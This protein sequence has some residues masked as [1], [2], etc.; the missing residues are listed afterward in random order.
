LAALLAP[1]VLWPVPADAGGYRLPDQDPEAIARGNAFVATADNPSAIYYNPAGIAQLEGNYI[2]AGAYF[3]LPGV[4]FQSPTGAK[5]SV[6]SDID[7]VP[8][9][10]V[11]SAPGEAPIAFGLG[12]YAP[13][14][15]SESWDQPNP[16]RTVGEKASLLYLSL[17]PVVAWKVHRTLSLAIGPTINYSRASL[18]R[19]IGVVPNDQFSVS[20]DGWALGFNAGA[21]WQPLPKWAFGLNYRSSTT[22]DYSGTS[23]ATPVP[24]FPPPATR[25][26]E[27]SIRFPQFAVG[28]VS[29]R[30]TEKWNLEFD[31][32]WTDWNSVKNIFFQGTAFGSQTLP[33]NF[34]SSFMYEFGVTRKLPRGY[35]VSLGYFFGANSSPNRNFTP[36]VA[37]SDLNVWSLG[38]GRKG[39]RW[40]W[41]VAYQLGYTATRQVSN[42]QTSPLADGAYHILN[43]SLSLSATY[44]F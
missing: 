7:T 34:R 15:L 11:V 39:K 43:Q 22:V 36:L 27:A 23:S 41:A 16:F 40:D 31:L 5:T 4:D 18:E 9:L 37:D 20:G 28:G 32:D 30:P 6:R 25:A 17:N 12:L 3:F 13:Y 35:F 14:G 8:E 44:K 26:S 38:L 2:Q 33:L 21:L 24:P 29:F 42:D 19:G 10:Y 1:L